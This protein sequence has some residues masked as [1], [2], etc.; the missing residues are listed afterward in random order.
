MYLPKGSIMKWNGNALT[1]HNREPL[2][3]DPIR[4]EEAERMANGTM[5]A[6]IVATKA[7][8]STSWSNLPDVDA[9]TVD[10]K[11][12]AR[13]ISNFYHNYPGSLSVEIYDGT[14]TKTYTMKI[15]NFSS[16]IVKRGESAGLWDVNVELEEI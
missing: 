2:S 4:I 15:T 16:Q 3:Y 12:G 1:E 8:F 7:K 14:E 10:K 6:Y 11:W 9:K 13:S 5:R